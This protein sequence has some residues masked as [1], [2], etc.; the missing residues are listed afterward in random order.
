MALTLSYWTISGIVLSLALILPSIMGLFSS[1][2]FD[3]NGKVREVQCYLEL[4]VSLTS[5]RPFF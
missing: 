5:C 2:K 3:V 1:N 4:T